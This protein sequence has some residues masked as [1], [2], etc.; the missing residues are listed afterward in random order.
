MIYPLASPVKS[1][2]VHSVGSLKEGAPGRE[3][4]TLIAYSIKHVCESGPLCRVWMFSVCFCGFGWLCDSEMPSVSVHTSGF[5]STQAAPSPVSS[6]HCFLLRN[7][8]WTGNREGALTESLGLSVYH[9]PWSF[10]A[11][12]QPSQVLLQF[13][14]P[15]PLQAIVFCIPSLLLLYSII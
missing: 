12:S 6:P 11:V 2:R 14:I 15:L 13:D 8:P 5:T 4:C 10:F 7:D 3:L 9:F 1:H